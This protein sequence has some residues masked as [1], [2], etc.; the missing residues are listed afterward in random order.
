MGADLDDRGVSK[1]EERRVAVT[2]LCHAR[3]PSK[4]AGI[5]IRVAQQE[6]KK[7]NPSLRLITKSEHPR[8][9]Y[10]IGLTPHRL[11]NRRVPPPGTP[12]FDVALY[13][14]SPSLLTPICSSQH[15]LG[16]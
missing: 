9:E 8:A 14:Q 4:L 15:Y 1:S 6:R 3:K 12:E 2:P 13:D 11:L 10:Q 7:G 16:I 5:F